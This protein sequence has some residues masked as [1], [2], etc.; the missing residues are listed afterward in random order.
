MRLKASLT[1][2][3]SIVISICFIMFGMAVCLA[4]ELFKE[5]IDYVSYN[6][7]SFDAVK[8]FRLKEGLVGIYHAIKD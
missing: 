3:G 6:R 4:Y 5:T 7:D 8:M 2:E 1:V